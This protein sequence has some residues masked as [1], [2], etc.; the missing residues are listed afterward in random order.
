MLISGNDCCTWPLRAARTSSVVMRD[1]RRSS[2]ERRM[3]GTDVAT[4]TR[5]RPGL[6]AFALEDGFI[7]HT[8]SAYARGLAGV[9]A[10]TSGSTARRKNETRPASG[11]AATTNTTGTER[12]REARERSAPRHSMQRIGLEG[13]VN[14]TAPPTF[15]DTNGTP[16]VEAIVQENPVIIAGRIVDK[17]P[18][19]LTLR[20]RQD[21]TAAP[22][23][24]EL[25]RFPSHR[26]SRPGHPNDGGISA[27][28]TAAVHVH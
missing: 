22:M 7:Y 3:T 12:R 5:E 24:D 16:F 17:Q 20:G 8:Y 4:Y 15:G 10:T 13:K 6:S 25:D 27:R 21:F 1:P 28:T 2:H 14:P 23:C 19:F 11:G 26:A 18:A 9:W